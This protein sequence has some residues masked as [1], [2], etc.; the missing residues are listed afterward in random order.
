LVLSSGEKKKDKTGFKQLRL[1][2]EYTFR[3]GCFD[4]LVLLLSCL[5]PSGITPEIFRRTM[6]TL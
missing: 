1:A 6:V 2:S 3:P 5:P 4:L